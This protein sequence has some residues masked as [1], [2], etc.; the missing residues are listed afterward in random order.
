MHPAHGSLARSALPP[1]RIC[2]K[3]NRAITLSDT[4]LADSDAVYDALDV[5]TPH[6]ALHE[7][8]AVAT[9]V[10]SL[11]VFGGLCI[12]EAAAVPRLSEATASRR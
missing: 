12:E 7:V 1:F 5:D 6:S 8:D 3:C 2:A 4:N 9:E 10:L 11:R